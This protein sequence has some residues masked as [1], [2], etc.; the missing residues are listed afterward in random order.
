MHVK[1]IIESWGMTQTEFAKRMGTTDKALSKLLDGKIPLFLDL[2]R[3][4]SRMEEILLKE[5][6]D[7][8]ARYDEQLV[9]RQQEAAL[10]EEMEI[11]RLIPQAV[12][13][14]LNFLHFEDTMETKWA[15]DTVKSDFGQNKMESEIARLCQFLQ[16]SSLR[17]LKEPYLF[18]SAQKAMLNQKEINFHKDNQQSIVN[19]LWMQYCVNFARKLLFNSQGLWISP[20]R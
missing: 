1:R 3:K 18:E 14:Q 20:M 4:L 16:I 12:L 6:L 15:Q 19:N 10:D 2:A 13:D 17:L 9:L 11:I 8:Q 5:W 7:I